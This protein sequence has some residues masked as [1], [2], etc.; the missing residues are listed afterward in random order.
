MNAEPDTSGATRAVLAHTDP[1]VRKAL[2]DLTTQGLGMQVVGESGDQTQLRDQVEALRPDLVI[3]AW[4]LVAADGVRAL[5]ELRGPR[6]DVR[7][8]VLGPRPDARPAALAAGADGY[9][10]MVDAPDVVAGILMPVTSSGP[11]HD[12]S[13]QRRSGTT[14][15]EKTQEPGGLS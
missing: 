11:S 14:G 1:T 6:E 5:E 13:T 7:V 10:S 8:V 3:V 12:P 2:R 15:G 9:I 4:K